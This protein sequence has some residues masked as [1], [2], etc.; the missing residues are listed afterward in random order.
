[1]SIDYYVVLGVSRSAD[2]GEIKRAYRRLAWQ[3]HPDVSKVAGGEEKFK[4]INEAY[5]A[6][7]DKRTRARY[8]RFGHVDEETDRR[9]G[10]WREHWTRSNSDR[11]KT[12][13]KEKTQTAARKKGGGPKSGSEQKNSTNE[14]EQRSR[15][16][17][18]ES[19]KVSY[20]SA[21]SY[22]NGEGLNQVKTGCVLALVGVIVLFLISPQFAS[23]F[24]S[25]SRAVNPAAH[26]E[27]LVSFLDS[28]PSFTPLPTYTALPTQ[29][30]LPTH[31]PLPTL[32]PRPTY[33]RYPTPTPIPPAEIIQ[34]MGPQSQLVVAQNET[35]ARDF[36]VSIRDGLCGHWAD[37]SAQGVI[38]AGIDF[39][40]LDSDS[41][42]YDPVSQSYRLNLPAT[43]ITSC[44]IEF[45]RLE[46][47]SFSLCNPD[48]DRARQ[49]AEYQVMAYFVEESQESVLLQEAEEL[50]EVLLGDFVRNLTGKPVD[51]IFEE[52]SGEPSVSASCRPVAP[53]NWEYDVSGR[54]WVKEE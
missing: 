3:Y 30:P 29:T 15:A 9:K 19:D 18:S 45:I 47:N 24:L 11:G 23:F 52:R 27:I 53:T 21:K 7:S 54:V 35:T 14:S 39:D 48:F 2:I 49:F 4:E 31:T 12:N 20:D 8:D 6:L 28:R 13:H 37:F 38:E 33:T 40:E 10:N 50:S 36:R 22:E 16:E 46:K 44:R 42:S 34:Q 17:P 5:E 41:V 25:L 26:N 51:V 43:E 1:M 32:T